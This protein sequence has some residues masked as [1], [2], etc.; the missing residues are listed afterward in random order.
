MTVLFEIAG[1]SNPKLAK[2]CYERGRRRIAEGALKVVEASPDINQVLAVAV[3]QPVA[4][5]TSHP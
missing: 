2:I 4:A 3:E 1:H 5:A